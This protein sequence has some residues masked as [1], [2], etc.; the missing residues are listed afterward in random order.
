MTPN[1]RFRAVRWLAVLAIVTTAIGCKSDSTPTAPPEMEQPPRVAER[2]RGTFGQNEQSE[3]RFT[4]T[5][6]GNVELKVIKLEPVPTLTVGLG[7]GR[8]DATADPSC[9]LFASDRR[10]VVGSTLLSANLAPG[11]YCVRIFD[12]GNVFP[13][14]TVTYT[15]EVLHP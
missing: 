11:E 15:V 9:S 1:T 8:F 12:V 13:D 5:A 6:T 10:V 3:H 4:V 7:I 14:A 2:F